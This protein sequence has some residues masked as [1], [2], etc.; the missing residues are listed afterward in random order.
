M[1]SKALKLAAGIVL[2]LAAAPLLLAQSGDGP[3]LQTRPETPPT[4]SIT[5]NANLVILTVVVRDRK[6]GALVNSLGKDDFVLKAGG[7]VLDAKDASVQ[8]QTIKY[9]DHDT[10]VPL[11]LGLLVDVSRSQRDALPDEKTGSEAFLT[12]S[13]AA[14]SPAA[15]GKPARPADKAFVVQFARQ[16]ELLEDVTDSRP[17]LEQGLHE[18][19]TESPTFHTTDDTGDNGNGTDSEGR[20]IRGGGTALYDAIYL[21]ANEVEAK[22]TGRKALV[23]LTDGGDVGSK[24]SLSDAI[25]AAQ[26]ADTIVYA[27]YYKGTEPR[28]NGGFRRGGGFPGGG[29]GGYPGGGGGYPGGGGG[30]PGGGGGG[31]PGGGGG[32]GGNRNPNGGGGDNRKPSVDGKQVLE[33]ICG[34]TGGAVF[35]VSKKDTVDSIFT[36][37]GEE[38]RSE[39]RLG[40]TPDAAA[41]K[42]GYHQIDLSLSKPDDNRKL[43]VQTRD[44]YYAD[45]AN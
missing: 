18:L 12:S 26:R 37:I 20:R 40:F 22:Q 25:E 44:G 30:Y 42:Y 7:R 27:V 41:A 32:G 2:S 11:T 4:S 16:I 39:Y 31:Y 17:K 14:A 5:V 9:F 33:R 23:V 38:L 34:E 45:D 24:E 28:D 19:G 10:D 36:R 29:G 1:E 8:P 35:E 21:S 13:L 3:K 15:A 6:D 43:R